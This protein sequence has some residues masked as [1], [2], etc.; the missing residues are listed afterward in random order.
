[1]IY[2]F[3][4]IYAPTS[5]PEIITIACHIDVG[6]THPK[7]DELVEHVIPLVAT[8]WY[9]LGLVLLDTRYKDLLD[10]MEKQCKQDVQSH[11][12]KMFSKWLETS[13][14][15][16]WYQIVEATRCID[17][18]DMANDIESLL[19]QGDRRAFVCVHA[20]TC[21]RMC[22]QYVCMH[23]VCGNMGLL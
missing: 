12:K 16:T 15:A 5:F 23:S 7:M 17:Q 20:C 9:G 2:P 13:D 14:I 22:V 3:K 19:L 8:K 11:C 10:V 6:K 21:V 4:F 18:K 1:M